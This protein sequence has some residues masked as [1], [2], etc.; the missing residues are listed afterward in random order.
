MFKSLYSKISVALEQN[1][2]QQYPT[3][4]NIENRKS[5]RTWATK[6]FNCTAVEFCW[7]NIFILRLDESFH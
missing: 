5:I 4:F 6:Y 3:G 1:D 2:Q 7:T